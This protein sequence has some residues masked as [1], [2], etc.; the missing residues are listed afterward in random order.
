M[1]HSQQIFAELQR[2]VKHV[3]LVPARHVVQV[4]RKR[5]PGTR[6]S[7]L[8][9]HVTGNLVSSIERAPLLPPLSVSYVRQKHMALETRNSASTDTLV[10]DDL[11][12]VHRRGANCWTHVGKADGFERRVQL[13]LQ[14]RP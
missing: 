11:A 1:F 12:R 10:G 7:A 9:K 8:K 2:G 6:T 13:Y 3:R 14:V 4:D 5:G